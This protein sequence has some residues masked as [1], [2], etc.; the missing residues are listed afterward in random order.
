MSCVVWEHR[1]YWTN[2]LGRTTDERIPKL[3]L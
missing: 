3:I 1:H 2:Y